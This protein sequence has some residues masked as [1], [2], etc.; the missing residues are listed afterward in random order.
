MRFDLSA[1]QEALASALD[2]L[3]QR[4]CSRERLRAAIDG[5]T[6]VDEQLWGALAGM[7]LFGIALPEEVG[8]AGGGLL[9][10]AVA[11]EALGS[12]AAPVPFLEHVLATAAVARTGSPEQLEQWLP[13]LL[14]GERRCTLATLADDLIWEPGRWSSRPDRPLVGT[15]TAV[16][17]AAT[18]DSLLVGLDHGFALVH[19]QDPAVTVEPLE[20][21]D[22]TRRISRVR[23][24]GPDYEL[25]K[26]TPD[27]MSWIRD[28]ALV[29]FA[30]DAAGG[31]AH[32]LSTAVDYATT[33]E[34]FGVTIG[35]FQA[36]KHRIADMALDV[37]P[38]RTLYWYA[39]HAV[40]TDSEDGPRAAAL[41]K[42]HLTETYVSTARKAIEVH[43]GIGYTWDCD[44]HIWLKRAILDRAQFGSPRVHRA[45]VAA[46]SEW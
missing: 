19:L 1:D 7:G 35:H 23:L 43:G 9:D 18:A 25:L 36:V 6:G 33:R 20:V 40:D 41:A 28:A 39:A 46:L 24:D 21:L 16:L 17:G 42:A 32:C 3:L 34:Q 45:R 5:G 12:A 14:A 4:E 30:A 15:A 13:P 38:A 8:G 31:A 37:E 11:M 2:T 10:L 22:L 26:A 27:A 29:L 44:L